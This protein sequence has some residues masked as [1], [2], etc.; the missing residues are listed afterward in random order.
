M[1]AN[2]QNVSQFKN[3]C[4]DYYYNMDTPRF[5]NVIQKS[6][7][8]SHLLIVYFPPSFFFFFWT[9]TIDNTVTSDSPVLLGE[10][11]K[12]L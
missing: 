6:I 9:F 10:F 7:F 1:I 2:I 4:K 3:V 11:L 12:P 8:E 5:L